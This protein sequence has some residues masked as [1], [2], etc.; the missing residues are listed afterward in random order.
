MS[1]ITTDDVKKLRYQTGISVMQCKQALEEAKGDF[2]EAF[3]ILKRKSKSAVQKKQDRELGAGAI[4]S[5]VHNTNNVGVIV[6]LACETDF[7]AKNEEFIGLAYDI[8]M[9]IAAMNPEYKSREDIPQE[10]MEKIKEMFEEELKDVPEGAKDKALAGKVDSY[11]SGQVLLD[12][13]FIKDSD[14]TIG[15]L[16]EKAVQ[17]FG[18]RVEL[19]RFQ[20]FAVGE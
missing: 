5:Y 14:N 12:Q 4:S 8:A 3:E 16:I 19:T 9:H 18:E 20:R 13:L 6:E 1:S 7:V 10:K 17:K 11:L 15:N 2:D